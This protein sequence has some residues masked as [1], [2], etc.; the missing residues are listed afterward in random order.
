M[1]LA[2]TTLGCPGWDIRTIAET[3]GRLGIEGLEIRGIQGIM[4][5]EEIPS[6]QEGNWTVTKKLLDDNGVKVYCL[7]TSCRFHEASEYDAMLDEGK[8]AIDTA[9]GIGA[10]AIRV[11][12]DRLTGNS[13]EDDAIFARVICG[14]R[15]LCDY[16]RGT[17]VRVC[18]ETHGS[19]NT[20]EA[21]GR[22]LDGMA[23]KPEFGYIW[24]V[25]HTYRAYG[26]PFE[27]VYSLLKSRVNHLHVKD[28][29]PN[30][31]LVACGEGD[32]PLPE[33]VSVLKADGYGGYLALEW[34]KVWHPDLAE[35]K[36]A[37][38]AFAEYFN[39]LLKR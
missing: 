25:M 26:R 14:Y 37:F 23:D 10:G 27:K 12:G 21:I 11:F 36:E 19:F 2:V 16:A 35:P 38:P 15:E 28:C 6:L 24:D 33:I 5:T 32:I 3:L 39:S 17:G 7:G 31:K 9:A 34:E 22:I 20:L 13:D 18:Q 8:A 30:H 29:L 1:K 4:R